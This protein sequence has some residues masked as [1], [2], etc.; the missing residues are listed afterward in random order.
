MRGALP[1]IWFVLAGTGFLAPLMGGL[2]AGGGASSLAFGLQ[3]SIFAGLHGIIIALTYLV[4]LRARPSSGLVAA[5]TIHAIFL[6][7][8]IL[9]AAAFARVQA[10]MFTQSDT[11]ISTTVMGQIGAISGGL[12]LLAMLVHVVALIVALNTKASASD[13]FN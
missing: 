5:S 9:A 3:Q 13:T 6:T 12:S 8:A 4:L 1:I 2:S 10:M 7:L 11:D